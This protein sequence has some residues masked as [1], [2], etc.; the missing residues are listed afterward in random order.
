MIPKG[1]VYFQFVWKDVTSNLPRDE[2]EM[3]VR[4]SK[5]NSAPEMKEMG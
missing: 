1:K 2:A 3:G 5:S 4:K